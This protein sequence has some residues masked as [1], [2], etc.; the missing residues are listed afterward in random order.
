[1]SADR[2]TRALASRP[3]RFNARE[4]SADGLDPAVVPK[5]RRTGALPD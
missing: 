4:F 2:G 5:R 1:M 3:G